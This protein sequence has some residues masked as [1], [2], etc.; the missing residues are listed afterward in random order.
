[1]RKVDTGEPVSLFFGSW[2]EIC[3]SSQTG[4]FLGHEVI[5][6]LEKRLS[7]KEIA[8]LDSAE[9]YARPILK[10]M[11]ECGGHAPSGF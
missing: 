9:A 8:L 4:H 5:V 6:E 1:L 3:G 7:L 11:M 10:Q 2:F